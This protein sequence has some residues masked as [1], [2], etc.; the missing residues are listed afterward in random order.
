MTLR[1]PLDTCIYITVIRSS[2]SYLECAELRRDESMNDG[3]KEENDSISAFSNGRKSITA[4]ETTACCTT[5]EEGGVHTPNK[6]L[7]A[8]ISWILTWC[9]AFPI[10]F[11]PSMDF[12]DMEYTTKNADVTKS[13]STTTATDSC[14][15]FLQLRPSIAL[16][17]FQSLF[18]HK[19]KNT[20]YHYTN[21]KLHNPFYNNQ[22]SH[23]LN[24]VTNS[25]HNLQYGEILPQT[26]FHILTL[27]QEKEEDEEELD[28]KQT[29]LH[30]V[31]DIGSGDGTLLF[32]MALFHPFHTAVGIEIVPSRHQEALQNLYIWNSQYHHFRS[33]TTTSPSNSSI[34]TQF[35]FL[36]QD[37]TDTT[38]TTTYPTNLLL[39][40]ANLVVIHATAFE[41]SFLACIEQRVIEHCASGTWFIMV[42]KPLGGRYNNNSSSANST[43]GSM[44]QTWKVLDHGGMDWGVG[45]IYIQRKV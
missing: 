16:I 18:P 39:Q 25:N 44:F 23:N 8:G 26:I 7:L 4:G 6:V 1:T 45:T 24:D 19:K 10:L 9:Q 28:T 20:L 22:G 27:C 30:N 13:L 31:I 15:L 12:Y 2:R 37:I 38:T 43:T 36:L 42:S 29:P 34:I 40:D 41:E 3:G 21:N 17:A 5:S 14:L 33:I 32:A 11:F 35:T